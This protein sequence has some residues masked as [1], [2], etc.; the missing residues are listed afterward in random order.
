MF[1]PE[2]EASPTHQ[3]ERLYKHTQLAVQE[4]LA[5][6]GLSLRDFWA[7]SI[8]CAQQ[9]IA[10]RTVAQALAVDP[11]EV[12]Y[13]VDRLEQRGWV[14][15]RQ[16]PADRRRHALSSTKAGRAAHEELHL[17]V[18]EAEQAALAVGPK[19][20]RQLGK[21]VAETFGESPRNLH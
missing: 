13:I 5:Q 1:S 4:A 17:L 19:R 7:L 2:M 6:H 12:T 21:L 3:L 18:T 20:L 10:Q 16:D 11:S 8:T 9:G 14:R 15:R